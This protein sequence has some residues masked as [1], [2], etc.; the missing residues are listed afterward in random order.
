MPS[1]TAFSSSTRWLC[2]ITAVLAAGIALTD[3]VCAAQTVAAAAN[4]ED[5][6]K[7]AYLF[8]FVKFVEWPAGAVHQADRLIV[9]F[10]GGAGVQRAFAKDLD[11]KRVGARQLV[12][13]RVSSNDALTECN[14]LYVDAT[15]LPLPL[16]S[17]HQLPVLTVSD[18]GEFTHSE[19]IIGLFLESNR[20]RFNIN[21][22]N[23]QRS[24]LRISSSLLQLAASVQRNQ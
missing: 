11:H 7:A 16:G 18:A 13:R 8:N 1:R 5:Q 17:V 10:A 3:G 20:L 21:I 9:C 12:L 4:R 22:D 2:R 6:F 23:A 14:A 19:G 24:G 15:Q